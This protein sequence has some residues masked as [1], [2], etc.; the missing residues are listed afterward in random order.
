MSDCCNPAVGH[1]LC[2]ALLDSQCVAHNYGRSIILQMM[3][4]SK[5]T[6]DRYGTTKKVINPVEKTLYAFPIQF[7]PNEKQ[8]E[9]AGIFE[10]VDVLVWTPT[11]D[12]TDAGITFEDANLI[13]DRVTIGGIT[14]QLS[15]KGLANQFLDQFLNITLGLK[16]E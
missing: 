16:K 10:N 11:Q 8:L 6:R 13:R 1:E 9:K 14:Y 5:I 15:A 7:N 2:G 12:W 3:T 4:E